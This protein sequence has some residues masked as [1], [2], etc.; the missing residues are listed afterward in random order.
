[1]Y[2][3]LKFNHRLL[4]LIQGQRTRKCFSFLFNDV[5]DSGGGIPQSQIFKLK[6]NSLYSHDLRSV[7]LT[8]V[9]FADN[10]SKKI[11][12][13]LNFPRLNYLHWVIVFISVNSFLMRDGYWKFFAI[14][15]PNIVK[16]MIHV[17]LPDDLGFMHKPKTYYWMLNTFL[18][19]RVH[20]IVLQELYVLDLY[21]QFLTSNENRI[22]AVK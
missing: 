4:S 7:H 17:T 10:D 22:V 11:I 21:G 16:H 1:M 12:T 3:V 9:I 19:F 2:F 6:K 13:P 15:R 5:K 14:R 18:H 20:C 8:T